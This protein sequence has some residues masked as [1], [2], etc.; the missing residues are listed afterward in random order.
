MAA[1]IEVIRIVVNACT[2]T[3]NYYLSSIFIV[4][5]DKPIVIIVHMVISRDIES[6]YSLSTY[7]QLRIA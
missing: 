5:N 7:S 1:M 3:A 6:Y 4:H 2:N